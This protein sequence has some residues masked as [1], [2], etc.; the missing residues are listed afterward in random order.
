MG[1]RWV[2]GAGEKGCAPRP[3]QP[4]L[5]SHQIAVQ[6]LLPALLD[7]GK[8]DRLRDLAVRVGRVGV[9]VVACCP[10]HKPP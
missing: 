7:A 5:T 8:L 1:E 3:T 2:W 10:I 9:T 6:G 4:P